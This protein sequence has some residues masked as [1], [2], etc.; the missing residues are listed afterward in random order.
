LIPLNSFHLLVLLVGSS[1][2]GNP[3]NS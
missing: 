1:L 2:F 3:P